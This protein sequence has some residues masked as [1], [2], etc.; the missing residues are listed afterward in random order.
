MF[1]ALAFLKVPHAYEIIEIGRAVS[2][3]Y[4]YLNEQGVFAVP[5]VH[6]ALTP[7]NGKHAVASTQDSS[8]ILSGDGSTLARVTT[9]CG[10]RVLYGANHQRLWPSDMP[11]RCHQ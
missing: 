1:S 9:E 2:S 5:P 10:I 6:E 11:Q 4:G 3:G 7:F 8:F